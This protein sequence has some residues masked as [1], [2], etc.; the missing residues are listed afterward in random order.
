MTA[1]RLCGRVRL[2]R[3]RP[4]C[5][6][7]LYY[8]SPGTV[9]Q[10]FSAPGEQKMRTESHLPGTYSS[11]EA[12][13]YESTRIRR[14]VHRRRTGLRRAGAALARPD[15]LVD[16]AVR[17]RVRRADLSD[18]GARAHRALAALDAVR[19]RR[20][21]GGVFHRRAGQPAPWLERLE[22][23]RPAAQR[24][25]A[26]LPAVY[27]V[28][29]WT[30]HPRRVA[31]ANRAAKNSPPGRLSK[32][33][34]AVPASLAVQPLPAA[35]ARPLPRQPAAPAPWRSSRCGWCRAGPRRGG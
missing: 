26:D 28:L 18:R 9:C 19:G 30:C 22:L 10:G 25:R 21:D 7:L 14:C 27:P 31:G 32:W 6:Q 5:C 17:R 33:C 12:K 29:V 1:D 11:T 16:A 24:P 4:L 8:S 23:R 13:P 34:P 2:P 3:G 35:A 20:H 15:A